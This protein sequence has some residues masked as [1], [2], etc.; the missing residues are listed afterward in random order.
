MTGVIALQRLQ[1][2]ERRDL[3]EVVERHPA[4]TIK[5]PRDRVGKRQ[6]C[7][8]QPFA[9]LTVTVIGLG[10]EVCPLTAIDL[11]R[12]VACGCARLTDRDENV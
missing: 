12:G 9:S 7:T 4:A 10:T 6:V 1:Q 11:A 5:A 8:D 3:L 2:A